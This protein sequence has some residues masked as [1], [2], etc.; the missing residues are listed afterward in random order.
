MY[1]L[2]RI[3]LLVVLLASFFNAGLAQND[4]V[5]DEIVWIVGDEIILRSQVEEQYK[6]MQ[7]EKQKIEGDPYCFIPEQMAVNKLFLHQ[8]GL[9]SITVSDSQVMQDVDRRINFFID[10]IGSKEKVE[11]YFGKS[12]H[13]LRELLT[14]MVRNQSIVQEMQRELVKDIK[15]TPS[16]VRRFYDVMPKDS[17]PFVP[18]QV[19][20]QILKL[21]PFIPQSDIDNIKARLREY[22]E[23]VINGETEFSTLAILY[24]EDPGSARQ[25][26]ETGFTG[27]AEWVPEFADAAFALND[28]KK[29]SKI[30]ETEFGYHIIQFVERRGDRVNVRHILLKPK[31]SEAEKEK[32]VA[33]LDSIRNDIING[34]FSFEEAVTA[35]SQDKDTRNNHG[36]M[37]NPNTGISKFEMADLPQEIAKAIA[38]LQPGEISMPFIMVDPKMGRDVAA[39]VKLKTRIPAHKANISDDYQMIKSIVENKRKGDF[40]EEWIKTKQKN[41]FVK[42]KDG[43]QNC[44]FKYDGWNLK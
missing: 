42:I 41:T 4:N 28:P 30:V 16:D 10:N 2:K 1:K 29:V 44:E 6:N 19:E 14:E 9:D 15:V 26:G 18:T 20:V 22:T 21:H 8:A 36:L 39:I 17:V 35:L 12:M 32:S 13:E 27:R 11:E 5:V 3:F 43:W 37:V 34:E 38:N 24:S 40:I 33:K 7:Y 23:R 31:A 25:G